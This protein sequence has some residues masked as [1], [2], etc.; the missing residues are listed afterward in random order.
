M[1][2]AAVMVDESD[3]QQDTLLKIVCC[4]MVQRA[5]S[6]GDDVFGVTQQSI[7]AGPYT[8]SLSYSNPGGDMYITK[9]EKRMLG[10]SGTG[11][12]RTLMYGMAGDR[13]ARC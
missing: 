7:T 11:K 10:I 12:G 4:N 3:A 5:M 1:L 6:T 9:S 13:D 2:A 8:Q